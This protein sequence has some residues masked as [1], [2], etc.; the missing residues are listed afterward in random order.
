MGNDNPV[1]LNPAEKPGHAE[2]N[3]PTKVPGDQRPGSVASRAPDWSTEDGV[4]RLDSDDSESGDGSNGK[5]GSYVSGE[6]LGTSVPSHGGEDKLETVKRE[7]RETTKVAKDQAGNVAE[8]A[9]AEVG[10]VA[11][12]AKSQAKDLFAQTQREIKEQADAQQSKAAAGLR[13]MG[14]QLRGMSDNSDQGGLA[15]DLVHEV[16]G[17]LS[18]VGSWLEQR[19][20]GSLVREVKSYARRNPGT[21]VAIAAVAGVVV[22]R[23]T[24][25][26]TAGD[27]DESGES[28]ISTTTEHVPPQPPIMHAGAEPLS[29]ADTPLYTQHAASTLDDVDPGSTGH[30]RRHTL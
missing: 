8:T 18:G 25:A 12:E 27:N 5:S 17:R 14:E 30:D 21:F 10:S 3:S 22:G 20:S 11:A 19:D 9:K 6:P 28:R 23:L 1:M 4:H 15:V 7:S 13:A 2:S 24:K 26:L 29:V 16:S